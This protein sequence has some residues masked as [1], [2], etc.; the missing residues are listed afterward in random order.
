M[1]DATPRFARGWSDKVSKGASMAALL[2]HTSDQARRILIQPQGFNWDQ[3]LNQLIAQPPLFQDAKVT[4]KHAIDAG[5]TARQLF[6]PEQGV[7]IQVPAGQVSLYLS[8]LDSYTGQNPK[9]YNCSIAQAECCEWEQ[10][11]FLNCN[12]PP[13]LFNLVYPPSFAY[14]LE[15]R[16]SAG[17]GLKFSPLN[18]NWTQVLDST[19]TVPMSSQEVSVRLKAQIINIHGYTS[20][21]GWVEFVWRCRA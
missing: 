13:P 6:V 4:V 11:L 9:I 10:S 18:N 2:T 20:S 3:D 19:T 16:A 14:A 7:S 15:V 17:G 21:D 8:V 5:T 1:R 12:E